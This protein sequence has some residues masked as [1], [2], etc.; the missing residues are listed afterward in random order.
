MSSKFCV[1]VLVVILKQFF[2]I[3]REITQ[4]MLIMANVR[5]NDCKE[6]IHNFYHVMLINRVAGM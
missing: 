5:L 3:E 4:Q 6:V 1:G 2:N